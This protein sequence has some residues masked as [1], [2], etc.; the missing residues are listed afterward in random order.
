MRVR[1]VYIDHACGV[2]LHSSDVCAHGKHRS[3]PTSSTWLREVSW[4]H[5]RPV[6]C[7]SSVER[8]RSRARDASYLSIPEPRCHGSH[9]WRSTESSVTIII[10]TSSYHLFGG[11]GRC[12]QSHFRPMVCA[13]SVER[14]HSRARNASY[15]SIHEL[16]WHGSHLRRSTWSSVTLTNFKSHNLFNVASGG[17]R[18]SS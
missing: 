2:A 7:A 13:S 18:R 1:Y 17:A 10:K 8:M 11:F 16:R 9:L 6:V 4:R 5:F 12:S 15:L 3:H 14:M